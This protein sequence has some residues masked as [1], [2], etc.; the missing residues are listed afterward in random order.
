M[1]EEKE[2]EGLKREMLDLAELLEN[3]GDEL[4]TEVVASIL[5]QLTEGRT[6][7]QVAD[8]YALMDDGV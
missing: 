2:L 8:E 5:R 7:T 3:L 6:A 4:D 1:A